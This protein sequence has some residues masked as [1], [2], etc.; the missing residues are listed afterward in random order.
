MKKFLVSFAVATMALIS[1]N[2]ANKMYGKYSFM[3]GKEKETHFGVEVTLSDKDYESSEEEPIEGAKELQLKLNLSEDIKPK[4]PGIDDPNYLE[5]FFA[6]MVADRLCDGLNGYYSIKEGVY[7]E[8]QRMALGFELFP[9]L[10]PIEVYSEFVENFIVSYYDK[11]GKM[12]TLILP[13]SLTDLQDQLCW[14]GY[15]FDVSYSKTIDPVTR[16]EHNII[17]IAFI[18]LETGNG[19]F[20][21][22]EKEDKT[23]TDGKYKID[24]PKPPSGRIDR[25]GTHPNADDVVYI[26]EKCGSKPG[27]GNNLFKDAAEYFEEEEFIFRDYHSLSVGLSKQE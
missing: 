25:I 15:F 7:D 16:E 20:A 23:I 22:S 14:Y 8:G 19:V 26:N 17:K 18:D 3:M 1:C 2:G 5:Q 10:L 27:V 6:Y 11:K 21:S 24:L 12:V 13:T 4:E 9:E